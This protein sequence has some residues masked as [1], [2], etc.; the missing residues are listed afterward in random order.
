M[1]AYICLGGLA[2]WDMASQGQVLVQDQ[3]ARG[4]RVWHS[5][6]MSLARDRSQFSAGL[7]ASL[8]QLLCDRCFA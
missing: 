4:E 2:E 6:W 7:Y 8:P 3:E 5:H 1:I